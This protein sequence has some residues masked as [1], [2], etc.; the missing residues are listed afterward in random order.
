MTSFTY[1]NPI[2]RGQE[3]NETLSP[4]IPLALARNIYE[5]KAPETESKA[6]G[7]YGVRNENIESDSRLFLPQ[8][9]RQ[10]SKGLQ[11]GREVTN[12]E[13]NPR[14]IREVG[15]YTKAGLTNG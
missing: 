8:P 7:L 2:T 4:R 1:Y 6:R 11:Y 14:E 9:Q 12:Q 5:H 10:A 13:L 3:Y 15:F